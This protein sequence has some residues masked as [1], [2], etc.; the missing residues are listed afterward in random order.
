MKRLISIFPITLNADQFIRVFL[1]IS[2]VGALLF[3]AKNA[4]AVESFCPGGTSPNPNVIFCDD[5]EASGPLVASGRYFEYGTGETANTFTLQAGVGYNGSYGMRAAIVPGNVSGGSLKV[6]FGRNPGAGMNNGIRTTEDFREIYY[7]F[8]VKFKTGWADGNDKLSRATSIVAADWSQA[9]IAHHWE[10]QTDHHLYIDP[11]RC[12]DLS[13]N[14]PKCSGY[15]D[16]AHMDWLGETQGAATFSSGAKIGQWVCVEQHVRLNDPGQSNGVQ[17]AWID[18][19]L[20]VSKTNLNFVGSY[21]AYAINAVF[22]ETWLNAG[23]TATEER[24]FDDIVIS[25]QRIGCIATSDT[26]PPHAPT[27]L[28]VK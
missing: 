7:R 24:Y 14:Q 18:G 26:N 28:I 5:F 16:F 1:F 13:T 27:G 9:M 17:E 23:A 11:V 3:P 2:V 25:T 4:F 10:S 8:Y 22:F 15:N 20:D 19:N 12:V 6:A 21:T